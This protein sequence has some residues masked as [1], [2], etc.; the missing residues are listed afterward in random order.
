M[1]GTDAELL[2]QLP[3]ID[4]RVAF[5]FDENDY[6]IDMIV[7]IKNIRIQDIEAL[8][9][10]AMKDY[11]PD[12]R[13]SVQPGD[14]LVGGENFGFGHPHSP[15]MRAMRHIGI[16]AVIAD[17][18]APTYYR[19][20][21]AM[22]FPQIIC[23]GV[24]SL[25]RRGHRVQVDWRGAQLRNLDRCAALPIELPSAAECRMLIAGGHLKNLQNELAAI[26]AAGTAKG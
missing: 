20:E 5:V 21:T 1:T 3:C 7:G 9:D 18:F 2:A 4:G 12:F 17:S 8:C 25:V 14:V 13:A 26:G 19:G 15:P 24:R 23:P 11:D 16:K 10:V 6:D 22:G